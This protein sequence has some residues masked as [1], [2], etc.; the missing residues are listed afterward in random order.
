MRKS[1]LRLGTVA[2]LLLSSLHT[3]AQE[4]SDSEKSLLESTL[5]KTTS[6]PCPLLGENVEVRIYHRQSPD[7]IEAGNRGILYLKNLGGHRVGT[8]SDESILSDYIQRGY[9]V[10]TFDYRHD[11]RAISPDLEKEVFTAFKPRA[12]NLQDRRLDHALFNGVEGY[13]PSRTYILPA[14]YRIR[15]D[16]PFYDLAKHAPFGTLEKLVEDWNAK[17]VPNIPGAQ[18]A[19]QH[20]DLKM[21]NGAPIRTEY[22]M[23]V[24]YPSLPRSP[25]P[26]LVRFATDLPKDPNAG[27]N[28]WHFL[29]FTLRGGAYATVEHCHTPLFVDYSKE[30][31]NDNYSLVKWIGLGLGQAALRQ[32]TAEA[33]SYGIDPDRIVGFGHSK[34]QYFVTRMLNPDHASQKE[35]SR[36][37]G[38]PEGSPEPQPH[39]D[40][41]CKMAAGYQSA[42]WGNFLHSAKD[43]DGNSI[44]TANYSPTIIAVGEKDP[45]PV[46]PPFHAFVKKLRDLGVKNQV[47]LFMPG[48]AHDSPHGWNPEKN[49][50]NYDIFL[51]FFDR[52]QNPPTAH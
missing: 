9:T 27:E 41:P 24:I 13:R 23:D 31:G 50:D 4:G 39:A 19:K 52:F 10:V 3:Q 8:E 18:P 44:L 48:I 30:L 47:E 36:F 42:G 11:P 14:G 2:L 33:T 29:G 12:N 5:R 26:I 28:Y 46:V 21:K 6:W 49:R 45:Y 25:V 32:L 16:V 43:Y 34:G 17:I 20:H 7:E 51:E 22:M 1:F 15:H 37:E 35:H 38:F 40:F